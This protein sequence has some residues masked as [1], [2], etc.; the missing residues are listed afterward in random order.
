MGALFLAKKKTRSMRTVCGVGALVFIL[1][2]QSC[3]KTNLLSPLVRL[4]IIK[5]TT[6]AV[7]VNFCTDPAVQQK[8]VEKMIIILDHSDS[9]QK[10][11]QMDAAGDG[12]PLLIN[13]LPNISTAYATDPT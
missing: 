4:Q 1:I 11:Y 10:N 6:S 8:Y 12:G 3:S 5:D 9:N 2:A 13:G 7:N